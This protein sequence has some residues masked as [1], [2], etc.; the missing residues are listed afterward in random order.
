MIALKA[1]PT[2]QVVVVVG[3][4]LQILQDRRKRLLEKKLLL[5][6]KEKWVGATSHLPMDTTIRVAMNGNPSPDLVAIGTSFRDPHH[7]TLEQR[8]PNG[9]YQDNPHPRTPYWMPKAHLSKGT[10]AAPAFGL[11]VYG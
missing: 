11:S 3:F 7:R 8:T 4:S 9:Y 5:S 2:T 1:K 10:D 6:K